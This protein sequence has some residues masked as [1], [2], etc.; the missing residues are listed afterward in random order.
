VREGEDGQV[1]KDG[2]QVEEEGVQ[3]EKPWRTAANEV[4]VMGTAVAA[5][6]ASSWK[7]FQMTLR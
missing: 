2:L 3:L 6:A 7:S 1:G 5:V 4:A